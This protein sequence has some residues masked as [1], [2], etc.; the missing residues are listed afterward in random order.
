MKRLVASSRRLS[1]VIERLADMP[2]GTLGFR[3]AGE[4]EREDYEHVT[5]DGAT[6]SWT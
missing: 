1:A 5:T 3:V 2:S 4:I 6:I